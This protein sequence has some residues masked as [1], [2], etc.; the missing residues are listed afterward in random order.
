MEL[1][2]SEEIIF[3]QPDVRCNPHCPLS[4]DDVEAI[5]V[6]SGLILRCRDAVGNV[7]LILI[8]VVMFIALAAIVLAVTAGKVNLFKAI[9]IG[10]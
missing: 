5:K 4:K 2:M 7:V 3:D 10:G 1:F 9:G 6:A 8:G